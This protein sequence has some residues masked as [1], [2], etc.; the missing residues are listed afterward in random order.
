VTSPNYGILGGN[1]AL[2]MFQYG[3]Q[4]GTQKR[5][6]GQ[7]REDRNALMALRERQEERQI[8]QDQRQQQQHETQQRRA[9][10]P[11]MERLLTGV[12]PENWGQR[13]QIAQEYGVDTTG[14]PQAYDP[15]WVDQQLQT[16]KMLN[17]PQGQE[18]LSS[19]G[20]QA[21]DAGF[22]PG[23]PEFTQ[24]VRQI[25]T[26]DM[27]QP[28]M[29]SGGETRLYTPDVFGGGSQAQGGPQ[30]GAVEDG[31]RF[32]GGNPADPASWE[33]VMTN[34]QGGQTLGAAAQQQAISPQDA[35][36]VRQSLGPNGQ[37]EFEDW[38]RRNNIVIGAR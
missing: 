1:N 13:V 24:A 27:A 37:A 23:T 26:A 8:Q 3:A 11:L 33:Q 9:D 17:T 36:R 29:G 18:A 32:K 34:E 25:V 10:L 22:R 20:K 2:A 30:P 35:E 14:L 5:Q 16:V 19:A 15:G 12:T 21:Q 7:Q 31:Y 38:I 6:E 4:L 28:Y